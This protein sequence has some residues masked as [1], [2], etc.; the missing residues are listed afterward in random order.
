[1]T[2]EKDSVAMV[3]PMHKF[4][5]LVSG[6]RTL[7]AVLIVLVVATAIHFAP[8][9]I[10]I[11]LGGIV[12][13]MGFEWTALCRI[14]LQRRAGMAIIG[15]AFSAML[16]TYFGHLYFSVG[17]LFF[18]AALCMFAGWLTYR[19]GF[20]W[21]ALGILYTGL[22]TA[23]CLWTFLR[24]P[25]PDGFIVWLIL[26][27]SLND[28]GAYIV[29]SLVGGPKLAPRI[30]PNKTW[31]GFFGGII[32]ALCGAAVYTVWKP[33][34]VNFNLYILMSVFIAIAATAGDLFESIV[35]RVHGAKNSGAIIPG[36]GGLF[37][38]LD[39]F[40]FVLPALFALHIFYPQI[41]DFFAVE[42]SVLQTVKE[43]L[44]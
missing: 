42:S 4:V 18:L 22:P 27:V 33:L 38:R 6:V 26:V 35:K 16:I 21:L 44:K 20:F 40:L 14:T 8:V 11:F 7:S 23:F 34:S 10:A 1:M 30:S 17:L 37:D 3:V 29:G 36:H 19:T 9:G 24:L 41:L 15:S 13:L 32:F 12:L 5:Q 28:I 43:A 39:G 25:N 2:I 31:A